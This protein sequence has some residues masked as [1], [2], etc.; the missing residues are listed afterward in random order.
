M[1]EKVLCGALLTNPIYRFFQ[2]REQK[3]EAT[4]INV[5]DQL[6]RKVSI[7]EPCQWSGAHMDMH[8]TGYLGRAVVLGMLCVQ[9]SREGHS[10]RTSGSGVQK[11]VA[12]FFVSGSAAQYFVFFPKT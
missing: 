8:Q 9:L 6:S 11:D 12:T 7:C 10:I 4:E 2:I 3:E 5:H 1:V